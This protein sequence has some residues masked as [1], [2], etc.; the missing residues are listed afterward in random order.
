M[1]LQK[2]K[3]CPAGKCDAEIYSVGELRF[4]IKCGAPNPNY[5]HTTEMTKAPRVCGKGEALCRLSVYSV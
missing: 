2:S 1:G 5:H 3:P 4:C